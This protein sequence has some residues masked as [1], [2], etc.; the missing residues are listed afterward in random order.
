VVKTP[1]VTHANPVKNYSP[2]PSSERFF[3]DFFLK[4]E[5]ALPLRA[6]SRHSPKGEGGLFLKQIKTYH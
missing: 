6:F 3:T 5:I 4:T 2:V 1:I